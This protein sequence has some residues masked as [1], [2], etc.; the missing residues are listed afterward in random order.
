M[1]ETQWMG[2]YRTLVERI[3]HLCNK[4]A[5][6]FTRPAFFDTPYKLT[7]IQIQIIEYLLEDR[8][9]NMSSVAQR[10]GIT[11]GAFSNNVTR[12]IGM[13]LLEKAHRPGNNKNLFVTVT[14]KGRGLYRDYSRFIYERWFRD[15]FKL[16]DQ[17]PE[18]HLKIFEDILQGFADTLV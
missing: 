5:T 16:A 4:S 10:L 18:E 7:A 2:R 1:T 11:R 15:M 14:P 3:I 12:L 8:D 13:G 9:E 17:I 6:H